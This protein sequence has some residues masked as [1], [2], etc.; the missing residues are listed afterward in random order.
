[1]SVLHLDFE[2]FSPLDLKAVGT[3]NYVRAPGFAVTAI[4]WAFDDEPVQS[5]V[6]PDTL[7]TPQVR[8]HIAQGGVIKAWNA[9][10]ERTV[11]RY[12]YSSDVMAEQMDCVMQRSAAF[13]L[14]MALQDAGDALKLGIVKDASARRLMLQMGRP[15]P[16]G[17]FWHLDPSPAAAVKLADLAAY[18]VQDVKAERALDRAIPPLGSPGARA[19]GC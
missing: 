1:M 9:A 5:A 15:K 14:P 16:D 6:W 17:N 12:H 19:V 8:A 4:A 11:L 7:L 2:T 13:G 10:F 18:C 3:E